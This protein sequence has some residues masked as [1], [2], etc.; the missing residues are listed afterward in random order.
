MSLLL[1]MT[2]QTLGQ[3]SVQHMSVE[4][5]FLYLQNRL[6]HIPGHRDT[7]TSLQSTLVSQLGK[8]VK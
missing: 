8:V 2:N 4:A 5:W 6:K 7:H 3:S 1:D